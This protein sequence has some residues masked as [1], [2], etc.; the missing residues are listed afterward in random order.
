MPTCLPE[1]IPP[2]PHRQR[3]G[4]APLCLDLVIEIRRAD[5]P[6][7][8]RLAGAHQLEGGYVVS[9]LRLDLAEICTA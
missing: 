5:Q 2:A 9:G 8:E 6:D 1:R 7:P 4:F 3:R